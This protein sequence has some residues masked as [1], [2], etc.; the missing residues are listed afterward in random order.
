[1]STYVRQSGSE[2]LQVTPAKVCTDSKLLNWEWV[3]ESVSFLSEVEFSNAG[4]RACSTRMSLS[5]FKVN[6]VFHLN[7]V[8]ITME[9]QRNCAKQDPYSKQY[10]NFHFKSNY[11]TIPSYADRASLCVKDA[12]VKLELCQLCFCSASWLLQAS[13]HAAGRSVAEFGCSFFG[14]ETK[15]VFHC[16]TPTLQFPGFTWCESLVDSLS[17]FSI[18]LELLTQ[19]SAGWRPESCVYSL[20]NNLCLWSLRPIFEVWQAVKVSYKYVFTG[21]FRY[22]FWK[23]SS[24]SI[25][26]LHNWE[27]DCTEVIWE[28]LLY[29]QTCISWIA[30]DCFI[31]VAMF[32]FISLDFMRLWKHLFSF[33]N[34]PMAF[35]QL[36]N[37]I[38][39][40]F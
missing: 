35:T 31:H 39:L 21:H 10:L 13:L 30:V 7:P 3:C 27:T 9:I 40:F 25:S 16:T 2:R 32:Y 8:C 37:R 5:F 18:S 38:R 14:S 4:P 11:A 26:P 33:Y 15:R 34:L 22:C 17:L 19:H 28:R 23:R 6:K 1:M 20:P 24:M 36:E 12:I 29:K